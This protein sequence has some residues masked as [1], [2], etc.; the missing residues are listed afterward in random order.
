[1]LSAPALRAMREIVASPPNAEGCCWLLLGAMQPRTKWGRW[2][3]KQ[4]GAELHAGEAA[5]A[6]LLEQHLPGAGWLVP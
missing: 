1:M 5:P 3:G 2:G 4:V 6:P